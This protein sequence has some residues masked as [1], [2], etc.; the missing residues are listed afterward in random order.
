MMGD[1]K[2]VKRGSC[3]I[4]YIKSIV[5][6]HQMSSTLWRLGYICVNVNVYEHFSHTDQLLTGSFLRTS[7]DDVLEPHRSL[8]QKDS[9]SSPMTASR[10]IVVSVCPPHSISATFRF[11][12]RVKHPQSI[13]IFAIINV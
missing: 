6:L 2:G 13:K 4:N 11:P 8:L 1:S 10:R 3:Y 7:I 12:A 9:L 5:E